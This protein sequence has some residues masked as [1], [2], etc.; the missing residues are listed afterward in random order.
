MEDSKILTKPEEF[1]FLQKYL[2]SKIMKQRR[3]LSLIY[4]LEQQEMEIM[5]LFSIKNVIILKILLFW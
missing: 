4:Y 3:N 5:A 2:K 1:K